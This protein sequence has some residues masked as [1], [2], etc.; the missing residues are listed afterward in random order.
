MRLYL[1]CLLACRVKV[2]W[3]DNM[4]CFYRYA[5]IHS[6]I[7]FSIF[8]YEIRNISETSEKSENSTLHPEALGACASNPMCK[9]CSASFSTSR[10]KARTNIHF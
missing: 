3:Q 7:R 6:E 10:G 2:R 1:L 8:R 4:I 5:W 9:I